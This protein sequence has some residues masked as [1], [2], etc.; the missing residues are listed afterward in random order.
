MFIKNFPDID[1]SAG[2][3]MELLELYQKPEEPR[4]A[5]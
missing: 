5:D 2:G 4:G 3:D 1:S